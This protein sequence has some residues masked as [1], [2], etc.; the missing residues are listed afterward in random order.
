MK[1]SVLM[2]ASFEKTADHLFNAS[3]N[4]RDDQIQGVSECIIMGIPMQ[5]GTGILKVRQRYVNHL[6]GVSG[7]V[8]EQR[9]H[10]YGMYVD[11]YS[12]A[13]YFLQLV[14]EL[15]CIKCLCVSINKP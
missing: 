10:A 2:L 1:D 14:H 12:I 5:I 4:G 11:I 9:M 6:G 13:L 8:G 3:V 7:G 15:A